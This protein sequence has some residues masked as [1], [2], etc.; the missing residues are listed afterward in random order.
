MSRVTLRTLRCDGTDQ[1]S[2]RVASASGRAGPAACLEYISQPTRLGHQAV[3][4]AG[5]LVQVP[6]PIPVARFEQSVRSPGEIPIS[7]VSVN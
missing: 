2:R 1:I 7:L 4:L 3:V 5:L 6:G